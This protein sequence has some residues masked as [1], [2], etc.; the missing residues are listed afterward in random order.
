[1]A[2]SP[3]GRYDRWGIL[4]ILTIIIGTPLL[5]F[6]LLA[7]PLIGFIDLSLLILSVAGILIIRRKVSALKRANPDLFKSLE[8]KEN[9]TKCA[10]CG[11]ELVFPHRCY[12]CGKHFCHEHILTKNHHCSNAPTVSFRTILLTSPVIILGGT[13]LLYASLMPESPI[14]IFNI[15]SGAL[16]GLGGVLVF[17]G[18]FGPIV[19]AWEE[20]QSKRVIGLVEKRP[21]G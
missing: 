3:I 9:S 6:L 5:P 11:A 8:P 7:M 13:A 15:H 14:S 17:L 21:S 16:L 10:I 18:I 2:K 20:R 1:M 12:Y 19:R 4:F